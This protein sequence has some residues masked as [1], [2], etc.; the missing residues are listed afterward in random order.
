MISLRLWGQPLVPPPFP[1]PPPEGHRWIMKMVPAQTMSTNKDGTVVVTTMTVVQSEPIPV[2]KPRWFTCI[3]T[4]GTCEAHFGTFAEVMTK[5]G[6]GTQQFVNTHLAVVAMSAT[7]NVVDVVWQFKDGFH[8]RMPLEKWT[9]LV[10]QIQPT[11]NTSKSVDGGVGRV[12]PKSP[13]V[14][15]PIPTPL[16][17]KKKSLSAPSKTLLTTQINPPSYPPI[18]NYTDI[19]STWRCVNNMGEFPDP[20]GEGMTSF[21]IELIWVSLPGHY[22]A[23]WYTTNAITDIN[24]WAKFPSTASCPTT[25]ETNVVYLPVMPSGRRIYCLRGT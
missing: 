14:L 7:Q 4:D 13:I 8:T 19:P 15:P 6:S 18:T 3:L 2:E 9:N 23:V 16:P 24:S 1:G 12:A 17:A 5:C 25:T 20:L 11:N 22:Y 10:H 21:R